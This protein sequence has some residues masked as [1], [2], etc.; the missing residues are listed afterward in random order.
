MAVI[1]RGSALGMLVVYPVFFLGVAGGAAG[2]YAAFPGLASPHDDGIERGGVPLGGGAVG[3]VLAGLLIYLLGLAVNRKRDVATMLDEP[4]ELFGGWFA[5]IGVL[6]L[7]LAAVGFV[8]AGLVWTLLIVWDV[9]VIA[10]L[11]V[12]SGRRKRTAA[13]R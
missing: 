1:V 8:G 5:V 7:P 10:A 13:G 3:L 2:A 12:R 6:F 9:L 4:V 11:V